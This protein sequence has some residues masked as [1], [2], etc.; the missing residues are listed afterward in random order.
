MEGG[1]TVGQ[2]SRGVLVND[3]LDERG[4][5]GDIPG[6]LV[7]APL[8][9]LEQG[10]SVLGRIVDVDMV[11]GDVGLQPKLLPPV[12]SPLCLSRDI[13]KQHMKDSMAF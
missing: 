8:F 3:I 6:S 9:P 5:E 11:G 13:S 2:A 12:S 7:A 4:F 10:K 1:N